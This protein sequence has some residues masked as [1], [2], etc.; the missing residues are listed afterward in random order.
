MDGVPFVWREIRVSS[1][2]LIH[3]KLYMVFDCIVLLL[4]TCSSFYQFVIKN[5]FVFRQFTVMQYNKSAI[6]L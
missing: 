4:F 1:V 2:H 5:L 3:T 6:Q